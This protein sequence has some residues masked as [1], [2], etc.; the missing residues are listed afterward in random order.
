[1]LK[2]SVSRAFSS[3][4]KEDPNLPS[5]AIDRVLEYSANG[6]DDLAKSRINDELVDRYTDFI[7]EAGFN[8]FDI[9]DDELDV[10]TSSILDKI[11][12]D[13]SHDNDDYEGRITDTHSNFTDE[14][15][16]IERLFER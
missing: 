9:F 16:D 12:E 6:Y 5:Y 1:M 4:F 13:N 11:I 2:E 3:G 7:S 10:D 15:G 14:A 8:N